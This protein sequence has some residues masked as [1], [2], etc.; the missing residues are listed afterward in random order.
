EQGAAAASRATDEQLDSLAKGDGGH[1]TRA[2]VH[3][4]QPSAYGKFGMCGRLDVYG[5]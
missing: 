4:E 2:R 1:L 5:S 3:A